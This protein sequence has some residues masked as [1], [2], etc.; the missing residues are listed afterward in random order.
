MRIKRRVKKMCREHARKTERENIERIIYQLLKKLNG[1]GQ[2]EE[3]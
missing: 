1:S 2:K 3:Q